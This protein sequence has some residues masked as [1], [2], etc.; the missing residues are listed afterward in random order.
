MSAEARLS[1][2]IL[3]PETASTILGVKPETLATWRRKGIGP[4]FV[5]LGSKKLAY[6]EKHVFEWLEAR[7][8]ASSKEAREIR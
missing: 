8:V 6:L 3:T 2:S 4:R 5:L 1:E 7:T